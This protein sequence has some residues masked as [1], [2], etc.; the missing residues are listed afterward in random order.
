MFLHDDVTSPY[1]SDVVLW[2]RSIRFTGGLWAVG[3]TAAGTRRGSGA[4]W[5]RA[6]R[7]QVVE[8][9]GQGA[10]AQT[11]DLRAQQQL[12]LLC[13]RQ[14]VQ[15][16]QLWRT[17]RKTNSITVS[18]VGSG[19]GVSM[20]LYEVDLRGSTS[21]SFSHIGEFFPRGAASITRWKYS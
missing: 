4:M 5:T 1:L 8:D 10:V 12:G 7:Q 14:Q 20:T 16:V 2:R 21:Q 6:A 18:L 3:R 15:N 9:E 13:R 17:A 11:G 19:A